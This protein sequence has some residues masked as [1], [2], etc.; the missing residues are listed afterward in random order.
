MKNNDILEMLNK[1]SLSLAPTYLRALAF[2]VDEFIISVLFAFIYWDQFSNSV[3]LEQT[4]LLINSMMIQVIILKIA[5]Q[6]FFVWMYGATLGK[7]LVKIKV[8]SLDLL[9]KPNFL[10]SFL[11]SIIRI[12]SEWAFYLGFAWAYT[13]LSKQTWHGKVARTLVVNA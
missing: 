9:D 7:M 8:I 11:R 2:F 10:V 6:S 1:Q 3:T 5:Y 13:N 4:I 12:I